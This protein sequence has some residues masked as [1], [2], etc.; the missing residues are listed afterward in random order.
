MN[1]KGK[2]AQTVVVSMTTLMYL[3]TSDTTQQINIPT[4][5]LFVEPLGSD[6]GS[7]LFTVKCFCQGIGN[8]LFS[9]NIIEG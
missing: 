1:M 6:A 5:S 8:H 4:P 9:R 7:E 3:K 2:P